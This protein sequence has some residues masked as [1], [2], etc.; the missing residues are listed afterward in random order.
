[1]GRFLAGVGAVVAAGV[2]LI[3]AYLAGRR[4]MW[5]SGRGCGTAAA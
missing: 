3:V 5:C 1:M 4:R 2:A